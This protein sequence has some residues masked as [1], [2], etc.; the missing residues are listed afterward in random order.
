MIGNPGVYELKDA[1]VVKTSI[2]NSK[3]E[4]KENFWKRE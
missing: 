3:L 2:S 4:F 1:A